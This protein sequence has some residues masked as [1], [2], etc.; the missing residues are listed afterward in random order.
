MTE[1]AA[2]STPVYPARLTIDAQASLS[3]ASTI[4][5]I[6]LIIPIAVL[7]QFLVSSGESA[8][9][10]VG[11][12]GDAVS[13]TTSVGFGILGTL[14]ILTVVMILF[15]KVYPRWWF[16][17]ALNLHRFITRVTAYF[18]LLTD[19]Y[20]STEDEQNVHLDLDYPD[21]KTQLN[22]G[23]PLVKWF[24]AI[25]HF[26]ILFFLGIAVF[27]VVI[28]SWFAIIFTGRYPAAFF[29]F[30]VGYLRWSWRVQAYALLL[31]TDKYPPFSL[32]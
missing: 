8:V 22:R 4:F 20:P 13:S 28:L 29:D 26:F 1:T 19:R 18:L 11:G 2:P 21:V 6:I 30:V 10:V 12:A 27:V 14:F 15:R 31:A 16:D 23:L 25:P 9:V 17:F 32:R 3:R 24:L 5:R 7:L